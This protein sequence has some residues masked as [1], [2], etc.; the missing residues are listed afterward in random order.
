MKKVYY[1]FGIFFFLGALIGSVFLFNVFKKTTVEN[2]EVEKKEKE[3][4]QQLTYTLP[5]YGISFSYPGKYFIANEKS[6]ETEEMIYRITLLQKNPNQYDTLSETKLDEEQNIIHITIF[7][8]LTKNDTANT[9]FEKYY[10][11][12]NLSLKEKVD[13]SI[14][15]K[16]GIQYNTEGDYKSKNILIA[17]PEFIYLFTVYY[18]DTMSEIVS[19]FDN[20]VSSISFIPPETTFD[21]PPI[22]EEETT[23]FLPDEM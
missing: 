23:I 13:I 12:S 9:F 3:T 7:D 21:L 4:I 10:T 22:P 15:G 18:N 11:S 5:E 6:T 19:D 14:A 20:L 1:I 17:Q 8:N 2:I 16:E